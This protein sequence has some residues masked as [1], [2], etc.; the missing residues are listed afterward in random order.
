[1]INF[2]NAVFNFGPPLLL[3]TILA[4]TIYYLRKPKYNLN[5]PPLVP[6]KYPLIGHTYEIRDDCEGFLRRCREKYGDMY[7]IYQYGKVYTIAGKD[8]APE[9]MKHKDAD[10]PGAVDMMFPIM[11]LLGSTGS[12]TREITKHLTIEITSLLPKLN[13]KLQPQIKISVE[14]YIG[15]SEE[16]KTIYFLLNKS[17]EILAFVAASVFLGEEL[18]KDEE[19][20]LS[21]ANFSKDVRQIFQTPRILAFIHPWLHRQLLFWKIKLGKNPVEKHQADLTKK[22]V[23]IVEKRIKEMREQG[24][25]YN[26]PLDVIQM[27]LDGGL[28]GEKENINYNHMAIHIYILAF[29][30]IFTTSLKLTNAIIDYAAETDYQKELLEE[31]DKIAKEFGT[32]GFPALDQIEKMVKLDSF[33]KESIRYNEHFLGLQK[34]NISSSPITLSNGYQLP[35]K[36]TVF[37]D[38]LSVTQSEELQGS[39]PTKFNP[40]RYLNKG[41]TTTRVDRAYLSFGLGRNAC[42]GRFFAMLQIKSFLSII[43]RNFK[44]SFVDGTKPKKLNF[45]GNRIP[46][47][48]GVI[49]EKR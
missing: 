40:V 25:K 22:L 4:L 32:D 39:N 34:A 16:P 6:Y 33:L 38:L 2:T 14:K 24:D 28:V 3:I 23:P 37:I 41:G 26:P 5:E 48:D 1:M 13:E 20:L 18:S 49:F 19:L 31:Q 10:F 46:S 15:L 43:I 7:N 17:Q 21:F 42:P 11:Q 30:S 12:S 47:N 36:R 35:S 9:L 44:I 8:S 29:S 45:E 27:L